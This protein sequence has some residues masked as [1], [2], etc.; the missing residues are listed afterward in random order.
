MRVLLILILVTVIFGLFLF[1]FVS[2][3]KVKGTK[4]IFY[5]I[6]IFSYSL[7]L[8]IFILF[9]YAIYDTIT[10]PPRIYHDKYIKLILETQKYQFYGA[11]FRNL[12]S[13]HGRIYSYEG[14]IQIKCLDKN[15]P[16]C[17]NGFLKLTP[18]KEEGKRFIKVIILIGV[19]FFPI[20]L[21]ANKEIT[22]YKGKITKSME[23]GFYK[24]NYTMNLKDITIKKV[25]SWYELIDNS[26]NMKI[27]ISAPYSKKD[28]DK[29]VGIIQRFQ[30]IKK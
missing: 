7:S 2:F 25:K 8:F 19:M 27:T 18:E 4:L 28:L 17:E 11:T 22:I 26:N 3:R 21:L 5:P 10:E 20:S 1:Y 24:K 13:K 14:E 23:F 12:D 29:I 15:D 30:N 9:T 6:K 16:K